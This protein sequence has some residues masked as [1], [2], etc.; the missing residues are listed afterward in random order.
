[1]P[2]DHRSLL[3]GGLLLIVA[4]CVAPTEQP[5]A[6]QPAPPAVSNPVVGGAAMDPARSIADNLATSSEHST[7]NSALRAAGLSERLSASGAYTLF[8]PSNSAFARLP[9]GT[10]ESLLAPA[11]KPLLGQVLSYHLVPGR[12][13][14]A[15]IAADIAARGG[16]ATYRTLHGG[17]IRLSMRGGTLMVLDGHGNNS[18]VRIADALA[19]NGVFHVLDGVLLPPS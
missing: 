10:L 5:R 17:S 9:N 11:N 3:A 19:S 7:L 1:M 4:G 18:Q 14:G 13:T 8:A 2:I 12:K 15:T 16:F 6:A